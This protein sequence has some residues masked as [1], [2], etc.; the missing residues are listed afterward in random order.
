MAYEGR[1]RD[2]NIM[3][4]VNYTDGRTA[5]ITVSPKLVE[6]GDYHVPAIA[7]ERQAKG[8]IPDGEIKGVKRVR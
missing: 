8:E 7:R 1:K 5:Y 6:G 3:F 4:A 2:Y